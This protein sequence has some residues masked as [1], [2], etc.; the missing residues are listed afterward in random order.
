MTEIRQSI[1]VRQVS[2]LLGANI[3]A[4]LIGLLAYP[5]ATRLYSPEDFAL[6]SLF[7]SIN[8]TLAIVVTGRYEEAIV[9]PQSEQ[10]ANSVFKLAIVLTLGCCLLMLPFCVFGSGF[11]ASIFHAPELRPWVPLLPFFVLS[12]G[13]WQV[14]NYYFIRSKQYKQIASYNVVQSSTNMALKCGLGYAG[15]LRSGLIVS[16]FLG[17]VVALLGSWWTTRHKLPKLREVTF[18]QLQ[19]A[20][21][22]Y[23]NFPKYVLL[24]NLVNSLSKNLPFLLLP[25]LMGI[26]EQ[27][28]FLSLAVTIALRPISFIGQ[29]LMQVLYRKMNDLYLQRKPMLPLLKKY[30]GYMLLIFVPSL[31]LVGFASEWLFA[32]I[33]GSEWAASGVLVRY[34]LPWLLLILLLDPL[35]FLPD[36]FSKQLTAMLLESLFLVVRFAALTIGAI[37]GG[38]MAAVIAYFS[39][40]TL[41]TIVMFVWY[42]TLVKRQTLKVL[43]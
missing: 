12:L 18:S 6:F 21:R 13:L 22:K 14:L 36:I 32:W 27:L 31:A 17:Q 15:F 3:I 5:I 8:S 7:I 39:A 23:A 33:F 4:Q 11:I 9:L 43:R 38:F 16:S 29:S 34:M 42:C 37:W 35:S 28:G 1:F 2:L 40:C 41:K 26:D 24:H 30:C 10:T 20:A 19:W 25:V